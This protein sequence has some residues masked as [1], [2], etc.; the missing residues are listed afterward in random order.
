MFLRIPW[1]LSRR[2][3]LIAVLIDSA[4]FSLLYPLAF[5]SRFGSWPGFSLPLTWWLEAWLLVSYV[6][7]RYH[8]G[9]DANW[10]RAIEQLGRSL[11]ALLLCIGLYLAYYWLTATAFGA[12]GS[13]GFL[14]P[15]LLAFAALSSLAQA[16]LAAMVPGGHKAPQTWLLLSPPEL[17]CELE[18]QRAWSRV[19]V[20]VRHCEFAS[21]ASRAD[22]AVGSVV[23]NFQALDPQQ[24]HQL[25]LL[26]SGGL[27]VLSLLGW[28]ERVLQ[29]FPPELLSA[30]DLLRGDF[31][32]PQG[33]I[34][35]RLKR[36]GDVALSAVLLVLALPLLLL[37]AL[38]IWLE[39]RGPIF[40]SQV[41]SGQA[42]TPFRIWKLRSMGVD[43]ERHGA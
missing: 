27:P 1:L 23:G 30:A 18:R 40:Y 32:I 10:A 42:G 35:L 17:A 26:Q 19:P 6:L 3:L 13:R 22:S 2:R 16:L 43:A 39:D 37:A 20:E 8:A 12:E 36:L 7:S 9:L 33:S 4:L 24:L 34:Q 28:C 25:L 14:L 31:T 38:L 29:R 11:A 15:V 41:R 21:L 5:Y